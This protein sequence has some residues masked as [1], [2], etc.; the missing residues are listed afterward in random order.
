MKRTLV[1]ASHE[2][3]FTQKK[4]N[5]QR[6]LMMHFANWKTRLAISPVTLVSNVRRYL[7]NLRAAEKTTG[8]SDSVRRM[9]ESIPSLLRQSRARATLNQDLSQRSV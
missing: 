7:G 3:S 8:S 2:P 6:M 9:R 5:M 1:S 4:S